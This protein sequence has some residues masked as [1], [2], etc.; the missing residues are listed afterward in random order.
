MYIINILV[1]GP[2]EN[3]QDNICLNMGVCFFCE[4]V[5]FCLCGCVF[6]FMWEWVCVFLIFL[7]T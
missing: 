4:G 2:Y 5:Y 6:F 1:F 7:K 3:F